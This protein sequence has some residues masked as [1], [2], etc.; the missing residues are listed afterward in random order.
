MYSDELNIALSDPPPPPLQFFPPKQDTWFPWQPE[1]QSPSQLQ[2]SSAVGGL[3]LEGGDVELGVEN[4][5]G[6]E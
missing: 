5:E 3:K 2:I 6:G 1:L 4:G